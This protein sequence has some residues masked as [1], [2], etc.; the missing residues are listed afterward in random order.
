MTTHTIEVEGTIQRQGITTYQY[1]THILVDRS[2]NT[3]YALRSDQVN[4]T[5][6]I[7]RYVRVSGSRIPGYPVDAGPAYLAVSDVQVLTS[8]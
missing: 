4:L 3:R 7:G 5:T 6:Y 8:S 2:G 1:G